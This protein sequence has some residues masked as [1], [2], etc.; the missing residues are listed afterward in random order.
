MNAWY[1]EKYIYKNMIFMLVIKMEQFCKIYSAGTLGEHTDPLFY[2]QF[3]STHTRSQESQI[4]PVGTN[5]PS[6]LE[7]MRNKT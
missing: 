4:Q 7:Q 5:Q 1:F 3:L 6:T 2:S